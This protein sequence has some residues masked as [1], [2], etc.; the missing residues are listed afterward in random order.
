MDGYHKTG[1][2]RMVTVTE[3]VTLF[4]RAFQPGVR[5]TGE[6]HPFWEF[7]F[8]EGGV[9]DVCVGGKEYRLEENQLMFYPPEVIHEGKTPFQ[10]ETS[11]AIVSFSCTAPELERLR[12]KVLTVEGELLPLLRETLAQGCGIFAWFDADEDGRGMYLRE[13]ADF[14]QLC[15]VKLLLEY[16][17]TSLLCGMEENGEK[18]WR[19]SYDRARLDTVLRY[20]EAHIGEEL[21]VEQIAKDCLLSVS[22]LKRL[23]REHIRQGVMAHFTMLKLERA[24]ELLRS[25]K[26]TVSEISQTLGFS[27]Q[28]YF[29]RLF[30]QKNGISPSEYREKR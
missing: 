27:S 21:T 29:S 19:S 9:L 18:D 13:D 15:R 28:F 12:G 1:L 10:Q 17:L 11:L 4:R 7:V 16:F 22:V 20:L 8:V 2:P 24:K 14:L 3:I 25:G 26:M 5:P 6:S 30:K 23:F